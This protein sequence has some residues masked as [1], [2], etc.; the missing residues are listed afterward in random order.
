MPLNKSALVRYYALDRCF[1]NPGRK[2]FFDDLLNAVNEALEEE[3]VEGIKRRQLFDDLNFMRIN[4]H[5]PIEGYPEG[6]KKYY[7][8]EDQNFSITNQPLNDAELNKLKDAMTIISRFKGMPQFE[9][10]DE[11]LNKLNYGLGVNKES[12]QIISFDSN[13]YL[14]GIE[15]LGQ[16]FNAISFKKVLKIEYQSYKSKTAIKVVFHP[17]FL[18]QYNNRWFL[19]GLN[20]EYGSITNFALDRI[21]K[22]KE[23]DIKY[24]EDLMPDFNEYFEDIFGVTKPVNGVVEKIHIKATP[25]RAPYVK[26]KPI[27]GSQKKVKEDETGYYFTIEV[28]PNNEFYQQ[29]F[30]FG[31]DLEIISPPQIRKFV[32]NKLKECLKKYK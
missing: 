12:R 24:N 13:D 6:K 19:L 28:I 10:V 22:I 1:S 5:A 17:Y 21:K 16:L 29:V 23:A 15:Y 26:S 8:Y 30:S 25:E 32:K 11:I 9:W 2:F 31:P 18:K 14:Q 3:G 27:H 20:N 4:W 7:R